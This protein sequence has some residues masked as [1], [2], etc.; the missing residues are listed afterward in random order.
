M[1]SAIQ[2]FIFAACWCAVVYGHGEL[3]VPKP[4][5]KEGVLSVGFIAEING[6]QI[7]DDYRAYNGWSDEAQN[8]AL[9]KQMFDSTKKYG[10]LKEIIDIT[11]QDCGNTIENAPPQNISSLQPPN[12]LQ[13][14]NEGSSEAFTATHAGP[15][16]AWIDGNRVFQHDDCANA[17]QDVIKTFQNANGLPIAEIPIDYSS[18]KGEC[19]FQ[20]YW[21]SLHNQMVQ[22]Y[23]NCVPLQG[24]SD[25]VAQSLAPVAAP[26]TSPLPAAAPVLEGT[27]APAQNGG[28]AY[29][30]KCKR[31]R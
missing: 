2:K 27:P 4:T 21:A 31:L 12:V 8:A 5:F 19:M 15:C 13:W 28:K 14:N 1:F 10:S 11:V 20:F 25:A 24:S 30:S 18:C 3:Q 23:K 6:N 22:Y 29:S 26:T 16:E 9:F 17:P 7:F